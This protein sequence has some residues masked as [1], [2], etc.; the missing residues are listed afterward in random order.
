MSSKTLVFDLDDTLALELDYLKSAYQEIANKVDPTNTRL[1]AFLLD[2]YQKNDNPFEQLC[3]LYPQYTVAALLQLYRNHV[4]TY[5]DNS[6]KSLLAELKANGCKLGLVTDGYS[7]TQRN[8][9][10][11]LEIEELFDLVVISEEFGSAKPSEANFAVFHQFKTDQY[12]YIAD[13]PAKDFVSPN[14][15]GWQTICLIDA[16]KNIHKQDYTKES[17]YLPRLKIDTLEQVLSIAL[18]V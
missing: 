13:N 17:L 14:A 1:F 15:L 9:L 4:P 16:G 10:K 3:S 5:P 11:A 8:K 2:A 6:C 12:Y 18:H 7:K